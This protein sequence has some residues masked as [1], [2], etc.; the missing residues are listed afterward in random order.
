MTISHGA[1]LYE[2]KAKRVYAVDQ[3]D[4]V[5]VEYKNDATAFNALKREQIEDKGRLNCQIS[6][7][8]FEVLERDGIPTHYLGLVDETWM[9]VQKVEVIPLEVV[10]RNVATDRSASKPRLPLAPAWSPPC[11]TSITRTMPSVIL[12]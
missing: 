5:L 11:L 1:L 8:L 2:G 6:A 4:R 7:R 9:A 3:D 12:C 10:L